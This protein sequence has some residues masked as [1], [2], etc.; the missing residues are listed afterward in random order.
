MAFGK[1]AAGDP[2]PQRPP[3]IIETDVNADGVGA[4]RTVVANPGG[5]DH[6]FIALAAGVVI[7]SAGA[8][9][10]APSL[11]SVFSSGVRPIEEVVAGL[12]LQQ[13]RTALALE[14]FPDE[15]GKAFMTSLA[16]HFPKAH[17]ALL[18]TLADSAMAGGDRDDLYLALNSWTANFA[19]DALPAVGR[20]GAE[21][22]DKAVALVQ[23][24]LHLVEQEAGGCTGRKIQAFLVNPKTLANLQRYDSRAYH[25]AM[26]ATRDFVELAAKGRNAPKVDTRLTANDSS[27]LQ[28]TF[29]SLIADPQ[30][31]NLVMSAAN[32]GMDQFQMQEKVMDELNI[33]QL[34][35]T[36]FIKLEN[37]PSGTK[38]RLWGTAMSGDP[39][40]LMNAQ[41]FASPFGG[42][43]DLS[44][45]A[46]NFQP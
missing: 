4:V 18:D 43:M 5:M 19:V 15:D 31:S 3:V 25:F 9:I 10:A 23:D 38:A 12:D 27:A 13:A 22:F 41:G 35:R 29:F 14:A 39:T 37:L 45:G 42:S 2:L 8:A 17:G 6:K 32:G 11:L 34:A 33:C 26:R 40:K 7:F 20:T 28:S 44:S 36:V 16:T 21:G 1:R 24:G 46:F 30:I